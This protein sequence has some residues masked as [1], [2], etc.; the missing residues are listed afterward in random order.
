MHKRYV[1]VVCAFV[2]GSS[3]QSMVQDKD[4]LNKLVDKFLSYTLTKDLK[5]DYQNGFVYKKEDTTPLLQPL[6]MAAIDQVHEIYKDFRKG[7]ALNDVHLIRK[8][9][10]SAGARIEFHGDLHGDVHTLCRWIKSLQ[11]E[12]I[13]NGFKITQDDVYFCFLGDYTD[14]GAYGAEVI[15]LILQLYL[16]NPKQVILIRG[17]HEDY[18]V[19]KHYGFVKELELKL[20]LDEKEIQSVFGIYDYL[21]VAFFLGCKNSDSGVDYILCCHGGIEPGYTFDTFLDDQNSFKAISKVKNPEAW[22]KEVLNQMKSVQSSITDYDEIIKKLGELNKN[23]FFSNFRSSSGFQWGDFDFDNKNP[24]GVIEVDFQYNRVALCKNYTDALLQSFDKNNHK[25]RAVFR[26]HQHDP[27]TIKTICKKGHGIYKLWPQESRQWSGQL[28][29]P[30]A[31]DEK[32]VWTFNVAPCVGYWEKLQGYETFDY[33]TVARLT[34]NPDFK[35]WVLVPRHIQE[36]KRLRSPLPPLSPRLEG[37]GESSGSNNNHESLSK[38]P[39][40]SV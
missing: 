12:G 8:K 31:V 40:K 15:F 32:S 28:G 1:L 14:R 38:E 2:Y 39:K 11:T 36:K 5:G 20:K 33:D 23:N 34:V 19:A 17:N 9:V 21:P 10:V 26:A 7:F 18:H 30:V 29:A 13:L 4:Q 25:V 35:N 3:I 6:F 24:G 16:Y 22:Y 37:T 27:G